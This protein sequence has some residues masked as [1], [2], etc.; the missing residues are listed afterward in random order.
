MNVKDGAFFFP[1]IDC[2]RKSASVATC[3]AARFTF[4]QR[5]RCAAAILRRADADIVRLGFAPFAME[6]TFCPLALAQ[7]S[8]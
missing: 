7:R 5:A 4:A 3:Y 8:L 1:S 2:F 6:T